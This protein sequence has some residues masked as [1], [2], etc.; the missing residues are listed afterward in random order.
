[1]KKSLILNGFFVS[2]KDITCCQESKSPD[3]QLFKK[4][5]LSYAHL[6]PLMKSGDACPN[7]R[8][9]QGITNGAFWYEVKGSEI[10]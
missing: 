6:N 2:S 5:A 9:D 4:L 7:D 8:F 1:M 3:N 10:T